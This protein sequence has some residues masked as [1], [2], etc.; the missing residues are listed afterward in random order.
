MAD[1]SSGGSPIEP[2]GQFDI[3]TLVPIEIFGLD[4]SFT[5]SALYMVFALIVVAGLHVAGDAR[6][7]AGARP[8][9]V[10]RRDVL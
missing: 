5:N 3:K 2:L 9:A 6:P 8:D 1:T 4:V 7:G 10:R